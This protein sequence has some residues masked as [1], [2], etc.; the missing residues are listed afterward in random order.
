MQL[1]NL[2]K[3]AKGL[4]VAVT[5]TVVGGVMAAPFL[6][7]Q[8]P[9]S[10]DRPAFEVAS[11]K[12][13]RS[14]RGG[15]LVFGNINP[16]PG[17]VD[18]FV[19]TS[20]VRR[21]IEDAY[22]LQDSQLA[23]RPSWVNSERYDIDAKVPDSI[24]ADAVARKLT[25]TQQLDQ[26]RLMLQSLLSDRFK[27]KLSHET[28]DLPVYSVIL[29]KGGLKIAPITGPPPSPAP[30]PPGQESIAV[31]GPVS[32]FVGV[33]PLLP[34]VN[35]RT[36]LDHTGLK[37]DYLWTLHWTPENPDPTFSDSAAATP[38]RPDSSGPSIFTAIQEQLGLKVESTKDLVDV[39]VIDHIEEPSPN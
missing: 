38:P 37:G 23:G 24:V 15:P 2:P 10:V 32:A 26:I 6:Q 25:R 1:A 39:L 21:L 29:A 13:N 3:S 7:T 33:L 8:S 12:P 4:V 27:L 5:M 28:K 9:T 35:G 19:A 31:F 30:R 18:R 34:E 11:I 16:P 17:P 20:T 22:N 14:G 36:V